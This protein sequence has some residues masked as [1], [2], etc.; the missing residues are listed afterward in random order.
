MHGSTNLG[1]CYARNALS[2]EATSSINAQSETSSCGVEFERDINVA[3][4]G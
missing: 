1:F 2:S 4:S 3:T